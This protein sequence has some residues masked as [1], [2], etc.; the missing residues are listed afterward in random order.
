MPG[1]LSGPT[2]TTLDA[3]ALLEINRL[4]LVARV[5][6]N[7]AHDINNALQVIGGSAELLS[8]RSEMGEAEQR[9]IHTISA[10]TGRAA[11]A[12]DRLSAY[13]RGDRAALQ[14]VDLSELAETAVALRD[15]T[16][17]GARVAVTIERAAPPYRASVSRSR[18]LQVFLNVLLNAEEALK[19]RR[20]GTIHIMVAR[21]GADCEV[22]FEDNGPGIGGDA[23]CRLNDPERLP[24]LG[25]GLSGIGLWVSAWIA[26]QHHG[27][28]EIAAPAGSGTSVTLVVPGV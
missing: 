24:P 7:V 3:E 25:P 27:R 23:P 11:M 28:L 17:H 1:P 13:S 26:A 4:R 2:S 22:S 15:Y 14:V 8:V 19:N 6:S 21:S 9:R 12:L 16:L 10:Q 18:I 5:V 20:D